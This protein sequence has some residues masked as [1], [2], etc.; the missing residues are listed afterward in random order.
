MQ[1]QYIWNMPLAAPGL[2][3]HG[4][5]SPKAKITNTVAYKIDGTIYPA[6]VTAADITLTTAQSIPTGTV[7]GVT[8][9]ANSAGTVSLGTGTSVANTTGA[10]PTANLPGA[11]DG[12][13]IV[14]WIIISNQ[15]GSNFVGGTTDLDASSLTVVYIDATACW[16]V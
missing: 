5:S 15:T 1:Q 8:V 4:A 9:Y 16:G 6:M 12:F 2:A 11:K 10:Y 13:A 7:I 3:I 14:G